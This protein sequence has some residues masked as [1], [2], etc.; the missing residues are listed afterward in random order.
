MNTIKTSNGEYLF[1]PSPDTRLSENDKFFV[2][3]SPEQIHKL[4]KVMH[5]EAKM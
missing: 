1:N 4:K 2:L 3:G 5:I